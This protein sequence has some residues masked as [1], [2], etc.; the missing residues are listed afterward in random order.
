MAEGIVNRLETIQIEV[1]HGQ[2]LPVAARMNHR[3]MQ[4]VGE[5]HAIGQG[6]QHVVVRNLL[7]LL[8]VLLDRSNV[9]EERNVLQDVALQV[10]HGADR[11]HLGI[12]FAVLAPV[13][14]LAVPMAG[15]RQLAPEIGVETGIVVSRLQ[16]ARL[17]PEHLFALVTGNAGESLVHIDDRAVRRSNQDAFTGMG[18]DAGGQLESIFRTFAHVDVGNHADETEFGAIRVEQLATGQAPPELRLIGAPVQAVEIDRRN[19]AGKQ[20]EHL[21]ARLFALQR[22][23]E[24][25]VLVAHEFVD[26]KAEHLAHPLIGLCDASLHVDHEDGDARSIEDLLQQDLTLP[27]R[28]QKIVETADQL[29][30]LVRANHRQR[31]Q[32]RVTVAHVREFVRSR[33]QRRELVPQPPECQEA[34]DE[35]QNDGR[36]QHPSL[37]LA[38]R[39]KRLFRRQQRDHEPVGDGNAFD[40]RQH[41]DALRVDLHPRPLETIDDAIEQRDDARAGEL[42]HDPRFVGRGDDEALLPGDEHIA[43][44]LAVMRLGNL[45]EKTRNAEIDRRGKR[46]NHPALVINKRHRQTEQRH[47]E[48]PAENRL[49]DRSLRLM[50][51]RSNDLAVD[52]VDTEPTGRRGIIGDRRTVLVEDQD[53]AVEQRLQRNSL[54][55]EALHGPRPRFLH[56]LR[57]RS[58][59]D[60]QRVQSGRQLALDLT[61]YQRNRRKLLLAEARLHVLAQNLAGVERQ[62][63]Y[64]RQENTQR[65]EHDLCA[66]RAPLE[67]W[68]VHSVLPFRQLELVW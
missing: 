53:S 55:E 48:L 31:A 33:V 15:R 58:G 10:A 56:R 29:S 34:G 21:F 16:H 7:K 20:C 42:L 32:C 19:L 61:R 6:R 18:E 37:R 66:E 46:A 44:G 45:I 41:F 25:H 4:P 13:P 43:A 12:H 60:F 14:D 47:L 23:N 51:R 1:G 36:Q 59:D 50:E 40:R 49:A 24:R 22:V 2:D 54:F 8:F 11:L 30:D 3:L 63:P 27:E 57:R 68:L 17:L 38:D 5:Q 39:R 9:G 65:G 52:V 67:G 28:F 35:G 26:R 64:P 62:G